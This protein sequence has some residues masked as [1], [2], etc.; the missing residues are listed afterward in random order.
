MF[1]GGKK[2]KFQNPLRQNYGHVRAM[3]DALAG[4][5]LPKR[6]VKSVVVCAVLQAPDPHF[7]LLPGARYGIRRRFRNRST[8]SV[9]H[10]PFHQH[11]AHISWRSLSLPPVPYLGHASAL[12]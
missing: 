3:E 2:H 10:H 11:Q 7:G 9:H 5:G 6:S 12:N 4:I 8:S 1:P